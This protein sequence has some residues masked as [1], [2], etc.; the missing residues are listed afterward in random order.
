MEH[1]ILIVDDE[2]SIRELFRD[3]LSDAG[4][5]V[6]LATNGDEALRILDNEN[7]MLIFLDLKLFGMDGI[8][9]CRQIRMTNHVAIIYAITGWSSLFEIEECR[10]AGFDDFF[11]KP[12]KFEQILE[13]VDE[14]F[15]KL[16][17]WMNRH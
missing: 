6:S 5:T 2:A 7:I 3:F 11:T 1:K 8:Q 10:E 13:V 17:R 15:K 9:L 4:Y 14:A 12:V 16:D